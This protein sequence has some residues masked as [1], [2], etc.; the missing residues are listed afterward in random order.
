MV[1]VFKKKDQVDFYINTFNEIN[2]SCYPIKE[3][4]Q[5]E[6]KIKNKPFFTGI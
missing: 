1:E 4:S 5:N 3:V 2:F 6:I